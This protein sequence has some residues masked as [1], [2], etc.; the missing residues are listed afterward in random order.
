L[1][2]SHSAQA[3]YSAAADLRR[4]VAQVFFEAISHRS[5]EARWKG[6]KVSYGLRG[7][8]DLERQSAS[9]LA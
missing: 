5:P 3:L 4:F 8:N 1:R 2:L 9:T 6:F 7:Q